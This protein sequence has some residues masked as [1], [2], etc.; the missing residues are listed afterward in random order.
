M[1]M[2]REEFE[3][4]LRELRERFAATREEVERARSS[5]ADPTEME[6]LRTVRSKE[7]IWVPC[8]PRRGP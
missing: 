2:E 8:A 1:K 7:G 3:E 6:A 5:A 4:E